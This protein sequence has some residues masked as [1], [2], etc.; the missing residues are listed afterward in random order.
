MAE[1]FFGAELLILSLIIAIGAAV[2]LIVRRL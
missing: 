1:S 2:W